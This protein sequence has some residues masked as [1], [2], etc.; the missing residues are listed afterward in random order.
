MSVLLT[1]LFLAAALVAT[2]AL[3]A[4][5][6]DEKPADAATDVSSDAAAADEKPEEEDDAAE[7]DATTETAEETAAAKD[8]ARKLRARHHEG[9]VALGVCG[10]RMTTLMW[11]YQSSVVDGR[12]DLQPAYEAIKESRT[13]LK[14]EA[15]RRAIEDGVGT[16]VSV[17]NEY[18][19]EYW[20]DLVNAAEKPDTFQKAHDDLFANVQECLTIFFGKR[21][22]ADTAEKTPEVD[23]EAGTEADDT[24]DEAGADDAISD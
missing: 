1:R 18:S 23:A 11:F 21:A 9:D 3:A 16:S 13:V 7:A 8:W 19:A 20:E 14:K 4:S 15:E 5:D 12:D 10:A 2:P 22:E 6:A 17:M 24:A